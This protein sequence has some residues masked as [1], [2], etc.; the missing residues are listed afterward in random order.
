MGAVLSTGWPGQDAGNATGTHLG[1]APGLSCRAERRREAAVAG[2]W[3]SAPAAADK[4]KVADTLPIV[5]DWSQYGRHAAPPLPAPAPELGPGCGTGLLAGWLHRLRAARPGRPRSSLVREGLV[6]AVTEDSRAARHLADADPIVGAAI[7]ATTVTVTIASPTADLEAA[8]SKLLIQARERLAAT[9][10]VDTTDGREL[11]GLVVSE[12]RE[13]TDSYGQVWYW[14]RG[15]LRVSEA[16]TVRDRPIRTG[17]GTAVSAW[18][19]RPVPRQYGN[20]W[21]CS[22]PT[23]TAAA[24]TRRDLRARL[25]RASAAGHCTL[26]AGEDLLLVF[27]ELTSNAF[28][29]GAGAV[30]VTIAASAAGWLLVISDEAPERAPVPARG[31]DRPLGG[32]GLDMVAGLSRDF[33][34]HPGGTRKSVWAELP[35]RG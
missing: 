32:L 25:H 21:T 16:P 28:R 5:A 6:A 3:P 22:L 7:P 27:E 4:G 33:G 31:R 20:G 2:R 19:L 29:H 26:E 17:G 18:P 14:F 13:S 12:P 24:R 30:D 34:W 35:L 1:D 15:T 9:G 11:T 8:T 23:A 10:Q